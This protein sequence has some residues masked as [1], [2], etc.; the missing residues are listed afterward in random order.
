MLTRQIALISESKQV[1]YQQTAIISAALQKQ[2]TRDFSPIWDIVAS[3]GSFASLD[4]IPL[5]YW[6]I[7]IKDDIGQPGAGGYHLD[8]NGQPYS[9]VLATD[10]VSI[11]CSHEMIEMLVDPFGNRLVASGSIM[12]GQGRVSYLVE[13]CDPCEADNYGY[14]INGILVSD[15]YTPH[16]FDPVKAD[17]VRYSF[18]S[19]IV[20]PKQVLPGGYLTWYV[21]ETGETWQAKYFGSKI[22]YNNL[23]K[24]ALNNQSRREIVDRLTVRPGKKRILKTLA[25]KKNRKVNTEIFSAHDITAS[26]GWANALRADITELDQMV[27]LDFSILFT[28][29]AGGITF[30]SEDFPGSPRNIKYDVGSSL[31][32]PQTFTIKQ[33]A[34]WHSVVI[35]GAVPDKGK[36]TVVINKGTIVIYSIDITLN[37]IMGTIV[38]NAGK[39][40]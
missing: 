34:D 4:D 7:I 16:Y 13:A 15:F 10:D 30:E 1:S 6:P 38:Y 32:N 12:D 23:G 24:I 29:G 11:D 5:G 17:G 22:Q 28:G 31:P 14:S 3:I 26:R 2:I 36:I 35:S 9:L 21:P 8:K 40:T 33:T 37:P 39:T 20:S 25:S 18:T 27:D 19:A